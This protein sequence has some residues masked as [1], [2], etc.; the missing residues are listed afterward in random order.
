MR[1]YGGKSKIAKDIASVLSSKTFYV[2]WEPFCGACSVTPKVQA[3]VRIA[4]D[5]HEDLILMWKAL[6]GGWTPPD[7]VTEE[8]YDQLKASDDPSPLRAFVGFGCSYGGKWFGGYARNK[9]RWNYAG[10]AKR[11]LARKLKTLGDVQFQ[12]ISYQDADAS[13]ILS[14][15]PTLVYCDPPYSASTADYDAGRFDSLSFWGWVRSLSKKALVYVSEYT[16]PDD[17]DVAW[18]RGVK[19]QMHG[20]TGLNIDRVEKLFT[21]KGGICENVD[22]DPTP[23]EEGVGD[24]PDEQPRQ[25]PDP[26]ASAEAHEEGVGDHPCQEGGGAVS[27]S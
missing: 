13:A 26:D 24:P 21:Y 20:K 18:C 10:F 2:Y 3:P 11:S 22:P 8:D 5:V 14:L 27:T 9:E 12:C 17:F 4:S 15:G 16:A 7:N 23:H 6:Q 25:R 19:T 1:Y